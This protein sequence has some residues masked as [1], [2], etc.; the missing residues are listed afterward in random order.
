VSRMSE[1]DMRHLKPN[2]RE[3]IVGTP[4]EFHYRLTLKG[5]AEGHVLF[6][7]NEGNWSFDAAPPGVWYRTAN[8][9]L[10]ALLDLFIDERRESRVGKPRPR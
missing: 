4:T 7:N 1:F 9:A 8:Q 3:R 10:D 5:H 2:E 6:R